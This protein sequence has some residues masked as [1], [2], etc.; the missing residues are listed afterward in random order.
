MMGKL[1][2]NKALASLLRMMSSFSKR[3]GIFRCEEREI[4]KEE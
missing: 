2:L 4:A 1:F 3:R